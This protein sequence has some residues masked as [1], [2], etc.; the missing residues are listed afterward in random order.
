M[1][2]AEKILELSEAKNPYSDDQFWIVYKDGKMEYVL[3][4]FK[5]E[6]DAKKDLAKWKKE[7]SD[8]KVVD[9]DPAFS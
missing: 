4:G 5:T 2:L 3:D 7:Y 6:A 9:Y 8:A 1:K